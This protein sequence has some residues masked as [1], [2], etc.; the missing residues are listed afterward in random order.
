MKKTS[1]DVNTRRICDHKIYVT[2]P[3]SFYLKPN[4]NKKATLLHYVIL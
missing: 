4:L 1:C 2:Y 3:F